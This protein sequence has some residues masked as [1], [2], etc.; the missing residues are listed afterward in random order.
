MGRKGDDAGADLVDPE[1][2]DVGVAGV[3]EQDVLRSH[4]PV[5][6]AEPM[7]DRDAG[8]HL[9][10]H[11]Q[12]LRRLQ[13]SVR[14]PLAELA[15]GHEPADHDRLARLPPVVEQGNDVRMIDAGDAL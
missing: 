3:V 2:G 15:A 14:D 8:G 4:A 10:D 9:L 12:G 7:G 13:P 6:D 1:V 11:R 5:H